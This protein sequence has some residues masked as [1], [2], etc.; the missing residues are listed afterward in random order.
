MA[1][2]EDLSSDP[3]HLSL[4]ATQPSMDESI[5]Q[6][7]QSWEKNAS[8]AWAELIRSSQFIDLMNR[9]MENWL[10]LKQQFD[11][12]TDKIL[13]A[14]HLATRFDQEQIL[15]RIGKLESQVDELE[16]RVER[17]TEIEE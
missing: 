14:H 15:R 7:V 6:D 2:D 10:L 8:Q 1:G 9:Q 16:D 17:M 4:V 12:A 11:R 5:W 13:Q 3:R